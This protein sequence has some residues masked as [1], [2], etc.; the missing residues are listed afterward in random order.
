MVVSVVVVT[1]VGVTKSSVGLGILSFKTNG[2]VVTVGSV[3]SGPETVSPVAGRS[4]V[5]IVRVSVLTLT[6]VG[7][8]PSEG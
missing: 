1:V 8:V 7:K 2:S 4:D 3:G 6:V 5:M